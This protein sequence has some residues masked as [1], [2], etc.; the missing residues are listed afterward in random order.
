MGVN[1]FYIHVDQENPLASSPDVDSF[2]IY[3]PGV[4]ILNSNNIQ[5]FWE[6]FGFGHC[7]QVQLGKP[8][9]VIFSR[10]LDQTFSR[11]SK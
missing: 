3:Y 1:F 6:G 2:K 8:S 7:F 10:V 5:S 4:L 9:C 11:S